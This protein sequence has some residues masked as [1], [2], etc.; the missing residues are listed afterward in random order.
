MVVY[1]SFN[2]F[3][4]CKS[5]SRLSKKKHKCMLDPIKY[6][7][8]RS[9]GHSWVLTEKFIGNQNDRIRTGEVNK[10]ALR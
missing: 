7:I 5:V 1:N 8:Y 9:L 6:H 10:D 3:K 4:F 2:S